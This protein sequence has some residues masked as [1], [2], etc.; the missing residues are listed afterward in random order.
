MAVKVYSVNSRIPVSIGG[1]VFKLAPYTQAQKIEMAEFSNL[2]GGEYLQNAS[3][4]TFRAM[5]FSIKGVEG[6]EDG[7]TGEPYKLEFDES[8]NLTD[9]CVNDLLNLEL[10]ENLV[11]ACLSFMKGVPK[12]IT[13]PVT[14]EKLEGVEIVAQDLGLKKNSPAVS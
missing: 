5:K 9:T 1:V 8:G 11:L 6:L 2:E 12:E 13:H 10:S 7:L 4:M 3:R 14:K